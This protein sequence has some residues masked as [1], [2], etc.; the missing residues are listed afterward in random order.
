MDDFKSMDDLPI[1]R[2]QALRR[3]TL[4]MGGALSLPVQAALR[5]EST[6]QTPVKLTP[7]QQLLLTELAEVILP[8][9]HTP[10]AKAAG[11][12]DFIVHVITH[13]TRAADREKFLEG[14]QKTDPIS[15]QKFG[16]A[17]AQL[18]A[19]R[20]AEVMDALARNEKEFFKNLREMTIVGYFTSEIGATQALE[21]L[22]VPGRY[23]G[24]IPLKPGQRAWAT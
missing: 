18:D 14:L 1:C 23:E 24:D 15:R 7:E 5:G 19:P 3:V 10:G 8:T 13:C 21:Y 16:K 12:G 2:R 9:T 11:A 4:L 17:F 6:G 22:P 20:R